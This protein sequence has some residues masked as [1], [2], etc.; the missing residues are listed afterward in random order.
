[1]EEALVL[2]ESKK[3][4]LMKEFLQ[5]KIRGIEIKFFYYFKIDFTRTDD[6]TKKDI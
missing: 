5:E 1:M 2:E 4:V 6:S 3:D